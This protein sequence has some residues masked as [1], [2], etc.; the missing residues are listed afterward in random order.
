MG[1]DG[2]GKPAGG[3]T[4]PPVVT[5]APTSGEKFSLDGPAVA[6]PAAEAGASEALQRLQRGELN[7]DDYLEQKVAEATAHL[8]SLPGD[9]LEFV[10][11]TLRAELRSD[12][13]LVE[14]VRRA[15]GATGGDLGQ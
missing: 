12:P 8:R 1:I 10:R 14:L 5:P 4:P 11:E 15:T 3:G 2:I 6:A 13:A 9:Q 7:L